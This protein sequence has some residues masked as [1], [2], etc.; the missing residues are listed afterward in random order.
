VRGLNEPVNEL[1]METHDLVQEMHGCRVSF[2]VS[3][4]LA[5]E[6]EGAAN[7]LGRREDGAGGNY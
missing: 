6:G 4:F 1:D 3:V 5:E 2:V 7:A